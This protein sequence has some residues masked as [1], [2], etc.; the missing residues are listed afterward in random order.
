MLTRLKRLP[1]S[2][3]GITFDWLWKLLYTIWGKHLKTNSG[4][5]HNAIDTCIL[6]SSSYAV[7]RSRTLG[8]IKKLD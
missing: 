5:M 1:F 6:Y 3:A 4:W 7:S 2:L 8:K